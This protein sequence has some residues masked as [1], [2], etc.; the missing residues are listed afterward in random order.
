MKHSSKLLLLSLF[1]VIAF[2]KL[3]F[4]ADKLNKK[5]DVVAIG[6]AMVDIIQVVSEEELKQIMPFGFKKSDSNK[7]DNDAATK[8]FAKMSNVSIIA[9]G[10]EANV[11][12]DIASLGGSAAFNAISANDKMGVIFKESLIKEGVVYSSPFAQNSEAG[13]ARCFTFIT[14]DKDRTFAVSAEIVTEIND[15]FVDYN[16]IKEAKVFYTDASNLS[17]ENQKKVTLKALN[18]AKENATRTAFNLNNNRYVDSYRD[19]II[20]LL[21]KIDIIVGSEKEAMNL[22]KV[23]NIDQAVELYLKT[24]KIVIITLGKNGAIIATNKQLLRVPS[25]VEKSKIIDLNGAGDAFIAGFLYGYTHDYSLEDAGKLG[26]KVAAQIIYQIGAR[27]T[28]SLKKAIFE[29]NN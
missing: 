5:Y 13:T 11:V 2:P 4:S 18:V 25:I 3:S 7:I 28:V 16:T 9:G 10:S 20:K 14:P 29:S 23:D 19:E 17:H 8:M 1:L 12:A 26:A 15:S 27:P 24:S 22:F 21:P 6:K